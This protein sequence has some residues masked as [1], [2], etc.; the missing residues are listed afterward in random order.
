MVGVGFTGSFSAEESNMTLESSFFKTNNRTAFFL[1]NLLNCP[2][3]TSLT[4]TA[5][6]KSSNSRSSIAFP[7]PKAFFRRANDIKP[8]VCGALTK[9]TVI[10]A[11][12]GHHKVSNIQCRFDELL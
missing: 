11:P 2:T 4:S 5:L 12:Q 1:N 7:I 8:Y 9:V 3:W 6:R 10:R